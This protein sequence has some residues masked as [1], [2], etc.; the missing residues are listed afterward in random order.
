MFKPKLLDVKENGAVITEKGKGFLMEFPEDEYRPPILHVQGSPYEMGYTHGYL[1]ADR[2]KDLTSIS[3]TPVAAVMGGWN[4][5]SG[6]PP[7]IRHI[8]KGIERLFNFI[9]RYQ[10]PAIEKQVPELLEEMKGLFKGLQDR[11]SPIT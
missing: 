1:L 10:M 5:E 6:K 7:K 9:E 11:G 4:V 8:K 3:G 2:I